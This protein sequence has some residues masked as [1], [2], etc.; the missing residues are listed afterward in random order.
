MFSEQRKHFL[1]VADEGA[2]KSIVISI[3]APP[4]QPASEDG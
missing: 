1:G 4:K 2:F 3:L